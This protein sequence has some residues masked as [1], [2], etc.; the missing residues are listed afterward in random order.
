MTTKLVHII[1]RLCMKL[2]IPYLTFLV[3]WPPCTY[4]AMF[5]GVEIVLVHRWKQ[6]T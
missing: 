2:R 4:D 3:D 6:L 1:A 5:M